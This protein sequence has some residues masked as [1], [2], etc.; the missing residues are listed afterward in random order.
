MLVPF[1][2][3]NPDKSNEPGKFPRLVA[4]LDVRLAASVHQSPLD[5]TSSI[6]WQA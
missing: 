2:G 3:S 5:R 4:T 1:H 6:A